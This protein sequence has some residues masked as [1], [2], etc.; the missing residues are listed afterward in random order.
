MRTTGSAL[1][2]SEGF[3]K[4]ERWKNILRFLV[5]I[6]LRFGIFADDR[7]VTLKNVII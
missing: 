6:Y 5:A 7:V 4:Y 3:E 2:W 1:W